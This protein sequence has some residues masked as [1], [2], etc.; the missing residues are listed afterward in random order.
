MFE[1]FNDLMVFVPLYEQIK[2]KIILLMI[3]YKQSI[4]EI[5]TERDSSGKEHKS[6]TRV[7]GDKVHQ[8]IE[9]KSDNKIQ[10][11][12]EIFKN[13]DQGYYFDINNLYPV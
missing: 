1:E 7:I 3:Y 9:K 8:V 10:E 4:E 13:M 6:V 12:E 5:R 11:T 2:F